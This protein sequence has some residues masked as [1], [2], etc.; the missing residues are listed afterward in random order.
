MPE[1]DQEQIAEL[2]AYYSSF[3]QGLKKKVS[4]SKAELEEAT[5]KADL[6]CELV[7]KNSALQVSEEQQEFFTRMLQHLKKQTELLQSGNFAGSSHIIF[8]NLMQVMQYSLI[9]NIPP[10]L[11]PSGIGKK[12]Q[13]VYT[14]GK[15]F[16]KVWGILSNPE[17]VQMTVGMSATVLGVGLIITAFAIS[18]SCPPFGILMLAGIC[19][20]GGI[21]VCQKVLANHKDAPEAMALS[22]SLAQLA[23]CAQTLTNNASAPGLAH[24]ATALLPTFR[25]IMDPE[26]SPMSKLQS[27]ATQALMPTL[28]NWKDTYENL[29]KF[30]SSDK[31]WEV[32]LPHALPGGKIPRNFTIMPKTGSEQHK[33][34]NQIHVQYDPHAK[35]T[36]FH[37]KTAAPTDSTILQMLTN[38]QKCGEVLTLNGSPKLLTQAIEI[39]YQQHIPIQVSERSMQRLQAKA[40]SEPACQIALDKLDRL[41]P[42]LRP[43]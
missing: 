25:G 12:I 4:L 22:N 23:S 38:A 35:S 8:A 31:K 9:N 17:K 41:R 34:A 36:K 19:I 1:L 24:G 5:T 10:E 2:S 13:D 3:L 7:R 39:A 20:A 30:I 29:R 37:I 33:K 28:A 43:E 14:T 26:L 27:I 15:N 18:F 6:L 21:A 32:H 42:D 11:L 40:E 16:I